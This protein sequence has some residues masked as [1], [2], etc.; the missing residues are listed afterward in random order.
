MKWRS[1]QVPSPGDR[2]SDDAA[3]V[4]ASLDE[5]LGPQKPRASPTRSTLVAAGAVW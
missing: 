4:L 1:F 5:A 2:N 3:P